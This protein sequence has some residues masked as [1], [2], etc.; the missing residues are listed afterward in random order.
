MSDAT[1]V[2]RTVGN[3]VIREV[4][5]EGGMATVYRAYDKYRGVDVAF[6]ALHQELTRDRDIV[7]R[8]ERETQIIRALNHQH[9][10]PLYDAG[11]IDDQLYMTMRLMD[12]GTLID[13]L[14]AA[15]AP[16]PI[17]QVIRWLS[18]LASALDY[19]HSRGVVHRDIKPGNILMDRAENVYLADF[20]VARIAGRSQ[21]T[22]VGVTMPGTIHYMSPEQVAG[23]ADID[24]RS[25]VYS[26][27]ILAYVLLTLRYPYDSAHEQ[28]IGIMHMSAPIP[29]VT[30][31]MPMLPP[32]IDAI[33]ARA[34]AKIP[35]Q[36]YS[37]AGAF[38]ADFVRVFMDPKRLQ[39][40]SS[41]PA[42]SPQSFHAIRR[43]W[44]LVAGCGVI[45][46]LILL[47]LASQ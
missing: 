10:V 43:Y 47:V 14:K 45:L 25:D 30:E 15:R 16:L 12:G 4:I 19:A 26:L 40:S 36:R 27:G 2:N 38:I 44:W 7:K 24:G 8:F 20:G 17:N 39:M 41:I 6:K 42:I 1:L 34:L 35:S 29:R 22:V 13:R 28:Q 18:Q 21:I 5:A 11:R 46:A 33:I 32:Q 23:K 9:I 31:V 37:T 3:Y